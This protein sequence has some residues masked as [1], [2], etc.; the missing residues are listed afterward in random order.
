MI[1]EIIDN[2]LHVLTDDDDQKDSR[3]MKLL[4]QLGESSRM[5]ISMIE[6]NNKDNLDL[7]SLMRFDL[8]KIS[9]SASRALLLHCIH[10]F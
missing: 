6:S 5:L 10:E 2:I 4:G 8:E 9:S 3:R 7:V 1:I